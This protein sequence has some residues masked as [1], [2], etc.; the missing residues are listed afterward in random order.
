M[1][2]TNKYDNWMVSPVS[3]TK[4][5]TTLSMWKYGDENEVRIELPLDEVERL[6]RALEFCR[7]VARG[8][9]TRKN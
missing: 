5:H 2:D 3:P 7:G 1:D 4:H 8:Y 9:E 6:I